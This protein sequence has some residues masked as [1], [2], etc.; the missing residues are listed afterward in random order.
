VS[1]HFD[2]KSDGCR[3]TFSRFDSNAF[4]AISTTSL[5]L[6]EPFRTR[7]G[8][9]EVSWLEATD[10]TDLGVDLKAPAERRGS[11]G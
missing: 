1:M 7:Q 9:V 8:V 3:V 5:G 4:L 6:R 11:R 2:G 10:R